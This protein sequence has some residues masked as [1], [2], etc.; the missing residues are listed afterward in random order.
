MITWNNLDTVK[1]YE[2]LQGVAKVN[3]AQVMAGE[4]GA[5]TEDEE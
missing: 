4:N 3:L 1:A 5:E 2:A